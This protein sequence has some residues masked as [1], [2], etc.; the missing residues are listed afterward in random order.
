MS[1]KFGC[2]ILAA[3]ESRRAG[4][5]KLAENYKGSPLLQWTVDLARSVGFSEVVVVLGAGETI[6]RERVDLAGCSVVVNREYAQGVSGS[7][8]MGL[9][10]LRPDT[11]AA[12]ILLGDMPDIT[13]AT[14]QK[15]MLAHEK[16]RLFFTLPTYRGKRGNPVIVDSSAFP[17]V[18]KLE[19]D[20]GIRQLF[21]LHPEA[22]QR[23]EVDDPAILFDIDTPRD[24]K[25]RSQV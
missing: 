17:E 10:G 18:L 1:L 4:K 24:F 5:L 2:V 21:G 14:L 3:G 7:I 22:V 8:K 15:L 25:L 9:K 23:V 20:T 13:K 11:D 19:G 6:L 16:I 12:V